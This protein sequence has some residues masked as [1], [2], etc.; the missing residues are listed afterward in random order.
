MQVLYT[1][2]LPIGTSWLFDQEMD[3]R[4]V[5]GGDVAAPHLAPSPCCRGEN[6]GRRVGKAWI[7]PSQ[8]FP[9]RPTSFSG[10][11]CQETRRIFPRSSG[12]FSTIWSYTNTRTYTHLHPTPATRSQIDRDPRPNGCN[13]N[14]EPHR[15][16]RRRWLPTT[17][18]V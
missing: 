5:L 17:T 13:R 12:L 7:V 14:E 4:T 8:K 2:V 11:S 10:L 16:P 18:G 1:L 3:Q 15:H 6:R 9:E